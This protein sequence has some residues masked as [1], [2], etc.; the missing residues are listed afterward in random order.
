MG[1]RENWGRTGRG[2]E[3]I[4]IAP[5]NVNIRLLCGKNGIWCKDHGFEQHPLLLKH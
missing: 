5:N 3:N 4:W 2:A 1:S